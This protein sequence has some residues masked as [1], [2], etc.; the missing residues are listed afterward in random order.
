MP[1]GAG[2]G[3]REAAVPRMRALDGAPVS[4]EAGEARAVRAGAPRR[5]RALCGAG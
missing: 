4:V 2:A 5:L 1:A 3:V